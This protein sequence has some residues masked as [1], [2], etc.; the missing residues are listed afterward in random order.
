MTLTDLS[1]CNLLHNRCVD[2]ENI[3]YINIMHV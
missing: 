2:Y 1:V 3:T